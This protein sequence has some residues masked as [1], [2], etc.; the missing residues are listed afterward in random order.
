MTGLQARRESTLVDRAL[1]YL[2]TGPSD[3]L[4][5]TERILGIPR[6]TPIVADRLVGALLGS[7]PRVGRLGDGRWILVA[8][9]SA[10]PSLDDAAFAVVD[11]ETT[12]GRPGRGDRITEI[13]VAVVQGKHVELL[14]EQLV[15]PGRPIPRGPV[16]ISNITDAMV[17]NCPEFPAVVDD[18]LSVLAGRVFVAHNV[19]FDWRFVSWEL[20]R[21]RGLGLDGPRI[22]TIGL[23]RRLVPGLK[24]R[25]LDS[26]AYYFG[27]DI[28]QRHRAGPDAFATARI[29]Q[30]LMA[31]AQ[32][33]G[34]STINDLAELSR[35]RKRRGRRKRRAHP[36][37]MGEL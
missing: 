4:V 30:R 16:Q 7:D 19:S 2:T 10:S 15:N 27:C 33:A 37:S 28:Q 14:F 31:L 24:S 8:P 21:A 25:S 5:L 17:R 32:E 36:E 12:G 6:A 34:V 1:E 22:C 9:N 26:L 23:A 11:V 3:S 18:V 35:R 20:K 13:A 29:L